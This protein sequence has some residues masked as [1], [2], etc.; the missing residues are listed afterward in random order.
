MKMLLID[1]KN[2]EV[3]PVDVGTLKEYYELLNC[4]TIDIVSRKIAG[5]YYEIICDDEGL[6][7]NMP[8]LSA[9]WKTTKKPALFGNLLIAG[10]AIDGELTSITSEDANAIMGS[11]ILCGVQGVDVI[12]PIVL[13]DEE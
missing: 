5:K 1:V 3:R 2:C 11:I 7:V 10:E 8:T 12:W 13:L 4:D 6:L 9:A